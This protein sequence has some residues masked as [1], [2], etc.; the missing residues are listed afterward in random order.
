MAEVL[1][2]DSLISSLKLAGIISI[3]YILVLWLSAVVWT[4]R[5]VKKRTSDPLSQSVATLL[6]GLF[7]LPGLIV[8]LVI[9]PHET[10]AESYERSLE[11]EAML[12]ELELDASACPNCRRPIESDFNVCP[13]C[14]ILLREPC[15]NCNKLVRTNWAACA[16]CGMERAPVRTAPLPR[17]AATTAP[18][19]P[20]ARQQT[21]A[22]QP[23]PAA[24]SQPRADR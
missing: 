17:E 2:S 12:H 6:V 7:N 24:V 3:A 9:R 19:R 4:Y 18:L 14:R 16:Y 15:V 23:A 21:A 22:A 13:Q 20:P 11:A 10:I 1:V 5:D 8:Y